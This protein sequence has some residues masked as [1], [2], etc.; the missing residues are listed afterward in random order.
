[1]TIRVFNVTFQL[2][3]RSNINYFV[4]NFR[5]V[6]RFYINLRQAYRIPDNQ[7]SN[8]SL[9]LN[10]DKFCCSVSLNNGWISN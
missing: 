4:R 1:M 2:S 9:K 7:F 8:K 3:L 6:N 10:Y 5:K